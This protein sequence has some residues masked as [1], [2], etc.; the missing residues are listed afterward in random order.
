MFYIKIADLKVQIDNK[1]KYVYNLCRDYMI[2]ECE[3]DITVSATPEQIEL[4]KVAS[5]D[6]KASDAYAEGVCIYR[7]ICKQLPQKFGAYLFHSALIEYEGRGYAFSAKSGT[8]KSTHIALWQK[9]FGESV[10]I[11]NGDKPILKCVGEDVIAYG[12]PWCGKENFSTNAS[13][14]L[15]AICF[16]ERD[17]NNSITRISA[18]DAISRIFHQILT[19]RDMETLDSLFPLLDHT[20]RTIPCYL[21]KCNMDPEAAHVAY[22]GM[23]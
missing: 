21:L 23:K 5:C 2:D 10:R 3:P 6:I 1:Y 17:A 12:T 4:E 19:P 20:L 9:E 14:P 18:G 16:M 15:R 7:N 8:G 22:N 11:I 13:V